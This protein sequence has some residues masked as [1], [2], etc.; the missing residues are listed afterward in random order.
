[1]TQAL[2]QLGKI[3]FEIDSQYEVASICTIT[4]AVQS[5]DGLLQEHPKK[6]AEQFD[7]FI[8]I[9]ELTVKDQVNYYLLDKAH[10]LDFIVS[11]IE[12]YP[13]LAKNKKGRASKLFKLAMDIVCSMSSQT[14]EQWLNPHDGFQAEDELDVDSQ[15]I[16]QI[17]STVDTL[18]L[19]ITF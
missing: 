19:S 15:T 4:V 9:L 14:S 12:K 6:V 16:T 1:M 10:I 3:I 17:M 18:A 2:V 13:K 7:K 8:S 5:L 11:V